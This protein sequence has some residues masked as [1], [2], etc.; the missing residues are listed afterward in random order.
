MQAQRGGP[1]WGLTGPIP[2]DIAVLIGVLFFTFSCQFFELG[3]PLVS[4]LRLSQEAWHSG[5]IWRL[6]SYPMAGSGMPGLWIVVEWLVLFMFARTI[7]FQLGRRRF[8][9]TLAT[10]AVIA[11]V[12]A[13]LVDAIT[14]TGGGAGGVGFVL[15]QGQRMVLAIVIAA[16]ATLN[17][18]ATVLLFFVLPVKA[19]WFLG[20]EI[21]FAFLGYLSSGDFPGFVGIAVAVGVTFWLLDGGSARQFRLRLEERWL[22]AKLKRHRSRSRAGGRRGNGEDNVRPGPWVN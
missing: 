1:N 20:I 6:A 15:M 11:A 21:L 2:T 8:W 18:S 22:R 19:G 10:A 16:F 9:R 4:A 14:G 12:V 3:R 7:F 17:R 5:Q 13:L